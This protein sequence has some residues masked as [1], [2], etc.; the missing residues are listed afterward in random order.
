MGQCSVIFDKNLTIVKTLFCVHLLPIWSVKNAMIYGFQKQISIYSTVFLQILK[1][2][3]DVDVEKLKED[4]A[5][6]FHTKNQPFFCFTV[7]SQKI[8]ELAFPPVPSRLEAKLLRLSYQFHVL[9]S[10]NT[11]R[12]ERVHG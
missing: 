6:L 9:G 1:C 3:G 4:H 11:V 8:E 7:S 5:H 2:L 10:V 12:K